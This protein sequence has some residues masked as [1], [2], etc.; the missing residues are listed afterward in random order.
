MFLLGSTGIGKTAILRMIEQQ[1][2]HVQFIELLDMSMSC[3][4]NSDA[5][6]FLRKLD[7]DLSLFFQAL[8]RHVLCIEFIKP[9]VPV[10]SEDKSRFF[11]N[12]IINTIMP[13]KKKEKFLD[14][15]Q[16]NENKFWNTLDQTVVEITENLNRQINAE[17][18]S[19][20]AKASARAG[21][22]RSLSQEKKSHFQQR[23]RKYVDSQLLSDLSYVISGLSDYMRGSRAQYYVLI[24]K[25][26][27]HWIDPALKFL[28]IQSLFEALKGL[29]KIRNFKVIVALRTD[30]YEKTIRDGFLGF[31]DRKE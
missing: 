9:A 15:V 22:A 29:R 6:H 14:F 13:D 3:L 26:D 23:A 24:D 31:S 27:D 4:A 11:V 17:L 12:R 7:I 16:Q 19:E 2:D 18:G 5:I 28:L 30:I 20:V 10:E 21:Y 25:I 8:W 1:A